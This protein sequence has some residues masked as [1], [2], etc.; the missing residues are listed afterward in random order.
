MPHIDRYADLYLNFQ[1]RQ[2]WLAELFAEMTFA[3]FQEFVDYCFQ[4]LDSASEAKE[5]AEFYRVKGLILALGRKKLEIGYFMDGLTDEERVALLNSATSY[6]NLA[7]GFYPTDKVPALELAWAAE[8]DYC[9]RFG[10]PSA[11]FS[12]TAPHRVFRVT[13][14]VNRRIR[15][16]RKNKA[17]AEQ[18]F[19]GE[20]TVEIEMPGDQRE[21]TH[22][23][24]QYKIIKD[25]PN[26]H[27]SKAGPIDTDAQE[28]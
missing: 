13:G 2:E 9:I 10:W 5:G 23:G 12:V 21:F 26:P 11:A 27:G 20:Q 19:A 17:Q 8:L 6:Y 3:E 16:F 7:R 24:V 28:I 14:M 18:Q 1:D 15:L 4:E 25:W 22:E